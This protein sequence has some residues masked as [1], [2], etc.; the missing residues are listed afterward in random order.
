MATLARPTSSHRTTAT[1]R[2]RD[3]R[4]IR[5]KKEQRT[6]IWSNLLRQTREAQA[7]SRTQ[8]VQHRELIVCGGSPDDQQ[9]FVRSLARPPPPAP[10]SRHR[11]QRGANVDTRR[12]KGEVRLSNRYAYGYGRV[13]LYSPPQQSA[14][15]AVLLGGKA[16]EVARLEL[17]TLPEPDAE[18][19]RTLRRLL[20]VRKR[21]D[22]DGEDADDG[23]LGG[24]A[25]G[26]DREGRR[27]A[28]CVLLSWKEPWRFLSLLR[29]WLQLIAHALLAPD[30]PAE[31]PLE[32]L[33]EH[34]LAL[35]VVVQHVEAQEVLER[36][37]YREETFDYISQCIRTCILPISAGLVHTSSSLPPQQPGSALSQTQKLLYSSLGLSLSALSPVLT[38]GSTPA[39]RED[40]APKH[41][42]VDRMAIVVPSGWDSAGKIRLLSENF[43]PESVL[44]AWAADLKVPFRQPA[45]PIQEDEENEAVPKTEHANGGAEQEVYATSDAGEEDPDLSARSFAPSK[46]LASAIATYEQAIVDHNAHKAHKP[47]Q[48]E[49]T[50]QPDQQFLAE[51]RAHLLHLEAEDAKHATKNPDHGQRVSNTSAGRAGASG[52]LS[53]EQTG[54]L[55]DLGAVS[56]NV[57]GVN[58]N[59]VTAEAA[60]ERLRRPQQPEESSPRVGSNP[61]LATSSPRTTTP[62]PP[63]REDR[64]VSTDTPIPAS[65]SST[66]ASGSAKSDDLPIDKLEEYFHSLM[67]RGGGGGSGASTPTN[68]GTGR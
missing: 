45:H 33:K 68:K 27:P 9:A 28:V 29:R 46:P 14:G 4:P 43:T 64:E 13:T 49:V 19:E 36:E 24:S 40:L 42:V 12:P 8:A 30:A 20:E 16:E 50:T 60:I 41:N 47:P 51:M 1:P 48:I 53:G 59:T 54:A 6:E 10:P 34:G 22:G 61:S 67:K 2:P 7:R 17:H 58:Y 52:L 66:R 55:G 65:T 3:D 56:F 38:K 31:D 44:E 37:N 26:A 35:T 15:V 63:K 21:R 32:V 5:H 57:G 25:M 18:Y 39:G 62:R 23:A 11:D